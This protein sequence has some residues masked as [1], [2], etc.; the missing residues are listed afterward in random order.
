MTTMIIF[1]NELEACISIVGLN[2][3]V[4]VVQV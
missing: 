2:V 1:G 3:L 4:L